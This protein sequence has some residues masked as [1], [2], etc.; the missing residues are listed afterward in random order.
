M[1]GSA[2]DIARQRL[3]APAGID[4]NDLDKITDYNVI[5]R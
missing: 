5:A 1:S 3:L 2:L 4:E